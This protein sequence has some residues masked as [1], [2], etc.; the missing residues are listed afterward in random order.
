MDGGG[1]GAFFRKRIGL[2]EAGNVKKYE[3]VTPFFL[4]LKIC[5][6]YLH[7]THE[8]YENLS[9]EERLKAQLYEKMTRERE[10]HFANKKPLPGA[11]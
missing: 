1:E 9:R 11:T 2:L 6:E 10:E 7:I 8:E 3:F 4:E 5:Y